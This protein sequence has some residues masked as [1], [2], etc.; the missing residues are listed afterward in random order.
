[1]TLSE[2]YKNIL[3]LKQ[4][5]IVLKTSGVNEVW[6]VHAV[7]SFAAAFQKAPTGSYMGV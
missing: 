4:G 3:F 2:C 7:Y 5:M 6:A 1:M